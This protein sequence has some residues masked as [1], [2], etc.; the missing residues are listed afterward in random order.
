MAIDTTIRWGTAEVVATDLVADDVRRIVLAPD[1]PVPARPGAHVD[2]RLKARG[3]GRDGGSGTLT[4]SYSVVRS[5]EGGRRL[6]LTVQLAR[7]GRG[8][9]RRMHAL[10]PGDRL[11]VTAPLQNFPLGVGAARYLLLAG[12]IGMTATIAMA[13][14]LHARGADYRLVVVGRSRTV[15]PYLEE[16]AER[17]GERLTVHVDDEGTGLDVAALVDG[18]A[19]DAAARRTELYMCGPIGL[20]DAVRRAWSTA[21]LPAPNLRFETFGNS[22]SWAPE[23]FVIRVPKLGRDVTVPA[24]TTALEALEAAGVPL[25][26]DCRKGEC[27]LCAVRISD[28]DGRVDHRDVFLDDTEKAAEDRLCLCVSRVA[29]PDRPALDGCSPSAP[30]SSSSPTD[31]AERGLLTLELP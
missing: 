8:G 11:P 30:T 1:R 31:T 12:G 2:V 4:R 26:S 15:L 3:D 21:G 27:G 16:L 17:H 9:S 14:T 23:E 22:G 28:L 7:P 25:L 19:T 29:R 24:D 5:E 18:V 13:E 10:R 20:M 6:T